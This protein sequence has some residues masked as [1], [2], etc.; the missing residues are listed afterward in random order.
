MGKELKGL[1]NSAKH[2]LEEVQ[3]WVAR[4]VGGGGDSRGRK[5]RRRRVII[6]D[7]AVDPNE[8]VVDLRDEGVEMA[9]ND[10]ALTQG[11]D[12]A[13]PVADQGKDRVGKSSMP[14]RGKEWL[15]MG[16][17]VKNLEIMIRFVYLLS[18][19]GCCRSCL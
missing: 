12:I 17:A 14:W 7:N 18:C 3:E 8:N 13:D 1:D 15:S 5:R 9:W 4:L 10:V 19:G 6:R 11:L 2:Q 16:S